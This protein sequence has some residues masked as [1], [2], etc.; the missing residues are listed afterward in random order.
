MVLY[1]GATEKRGKFQATKSNRYTLGQTYQVDSSAFFFTP[2]LAFAQTF[3][4]AVTCVEVHASKFLDLREGAWG[5]DD[6]EVLKILENHFGERVGFYPP[7]ELWAVLDDKPSADAIKS[8]GYEAVWF[9]ERDIKGEPHDTCAVFDAER[10][11]VVS[12]AHIDRGLQ[13]LAAVEGLRR[14]FF[15]P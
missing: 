15:K 9:L 14:L 11:K 4:Q 12:P 8:L 5:Q 1:H 6:P 10:F 13:A 7:D 2:D 3:G